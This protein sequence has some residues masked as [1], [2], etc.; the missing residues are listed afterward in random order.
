[1]TGP[2]LEKE[3]G[4]AGEE[5]RPAE[6]LA[7]RKNDREVLHAGSVGILPKREAPRIHM[8]ILYEPGS[9][10]GRRGE[11]TSTYSGGC[12]G[13]SVASE[14]L[15]PSWRWEKEDSIEALKENDDLDGR[16]LQNGRQSGYAIQTQV[17]VSEGDTF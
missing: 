1:M 17:S 4:E 3:G 16:L 15:R 9:W 5:A 12:G 2:A 14:T 13:T 7:K 10:V 6:W 8:H 11:S